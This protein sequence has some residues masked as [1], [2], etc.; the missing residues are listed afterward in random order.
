MTIE[1]K[2][3]EAEMAFMQLP[4]PKER[5]EAWRHTFVERL[6][7]E[8]FQALSEPSIRLSPV[9]KEAAAKG[10]V[11]CDM[12]TA[13]E[14]HAGKIA[15][16]YLSDVKLMDKFIALAASK[17]QNGVFLFVPR[18]V[19]IETPLIASLECSGNAALFNLVI[20]EKGSAAHYL[21]EYAFESSLE[22][23]SATL[24]HIHVGEHAKLDMH[25]LNTATALHR[26]VSNLVAHVGQH[27]MMN[28]HWGG[29][30]GKLNR[31]KIETF[32][33]G[34]SSATENYGIIIGTNKEH[35]DATTNVY[36]SAENTTNNMMVNGIMKGTSSAIYRGLIKIGKNARGTNSYL[37]NHIL[38]LSEHA[39]ANSIPALEID[40][41]EVKASHGATVGQVD[42]EQL[43]YLRSRGLSKEEAE[44]LIVDGFFAPIL[45]KIISPSIQ[46]KF[47]AAIEG[48]R[49]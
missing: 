10:V 44:S 19:H 5:E 1:Q 25:Y 12:K 7:I 38:K 48:V 15:T 3:K 37:S 39:I 36:H 49:S 6:R 2:R 21:E 22:T 30:G 4:M 26:N 47:K 32:L 46:E 27:G 29:F 42:D 11:F 35:L 13:L 14:Q 45:S 24:T 17:W 8:Q 20:L 33:D 28:W 40:N 16:H 31:V 43:F 18:D 23:L 41:N 34:N 9:P